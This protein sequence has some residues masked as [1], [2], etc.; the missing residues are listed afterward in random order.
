MDFRRVRVF[1]V[2]LGFIEIAAAIVLSA[3]PA[4][5][6]LSAMEF[7]RYCG[8]CPVIKGNKW[9]STKWMRVHEYKIHT[10]CDGFVTYDYHENLAA[11]LLG[12]KSAIV[13]LYL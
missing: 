7:A 8:G 12:I 6:K 1:Y 2:N 4:T 9:S 5:S 13:L 11:L 3:T 10:F